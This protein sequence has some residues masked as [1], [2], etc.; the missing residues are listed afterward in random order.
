MTALAWTDVERITQ[1]RL[2]RTVRTPCPFCSHS[3]RAINRRKPVFAVK[4]KE[5]DFAIYNCVHC[6]ENGYIHPQKS[7]VI[8]LVERKALR[9]KADRRER[10]D[11]QRRTASA[12]Q[13]WNESKPFRGS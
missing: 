8:D 13:L 2:G 3:R 10:E 1:G 12:L 11:K 9:A 7:K 6:G 4:L 5:P